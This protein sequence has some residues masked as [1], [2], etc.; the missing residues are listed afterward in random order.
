MPKVFWEGPHSSKG[1][2]ITQKLP[3]TRLGLV[4]SAREAGFMS[5]PVMGHL[6]TPKALEIN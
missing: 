3:V 2:G 4:E 6:V 5:A 1:I